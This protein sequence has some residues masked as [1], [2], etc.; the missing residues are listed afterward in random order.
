MK[1]TLLVVLL[2]IAAPICYSQTLEQVIRNLSAQIAQKSARKNRTVLALADF[3]NN[4]GK[5]DPLTKYVTEQ[6]ENTLAQDTLLSIIERKQVKQLLAEHNLQSQGLIDQSTARSAI[7]FIKADGWMMGE[8]TSF[9]D[10]VKI[11]IKVI[12]VTTSEIFAAASSS[13]FSDPAITKLLESTESQNEPPVKKDC[14]EKNTGDFCFINNGRFATQYNVPV[15]VTIFLSEG[16]TIKATIQP[17]EKECAYNLPCG[18]YEYYALLQRV[19]PDVRVQYTGRG[20]Y[21]STGQIR[22]ERCKSNVVNIR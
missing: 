12:D 9:N 4:A 16:N 18:S 13:L 15:D 22:V 11:S 6:L 3:T 21:T 8:V 5:S 19:G 17:G 2:L 7:A 1:C 14:I 20:A 10:Q